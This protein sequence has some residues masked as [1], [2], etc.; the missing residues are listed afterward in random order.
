[1]DELTALDAM[2][3]LARWRLTTAAAP[4]ITQQSVLPTAPH[5]DQPMGG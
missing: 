3:L 4:A 1:M 5:S 2:L